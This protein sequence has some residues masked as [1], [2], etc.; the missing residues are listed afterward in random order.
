MGLIGARLEVRDGDV[1]AAALHQGVRYRTTT[2]PK[3]DRR[4]PA[5]TALNEKGRLFVEQVPRS[6]RVPRV[7]LGGAR[8]EEQRLRRER[9][10]RCCFPQQTQN[11]AA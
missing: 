1:S 5:D 8:G 3:N 7:L 2:R 11:A 6:L 4:N 9:L 10:V